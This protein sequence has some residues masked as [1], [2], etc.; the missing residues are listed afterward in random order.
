MTGEK[1]SCSKKNTVDCG[2]RRTFPGKRA[3]A[4]PLNAFLKGDTINRNAF[5]FS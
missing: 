2:T 1:I 5:C 4:F 3:T